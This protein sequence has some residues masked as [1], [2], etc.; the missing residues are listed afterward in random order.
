MA[1]SSF[2]SGSFLNEL[3]LSKIVL[4]LFIHSVFKLPL[5]HALTAPCIFTPLTPHVIGCCCFSLSF[6]GLSPLYGR[7]AQ[8]FEVKELSCAE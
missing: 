1:S 4:Q 8:R 3:F 5:L 7:D 2:Y 6:P